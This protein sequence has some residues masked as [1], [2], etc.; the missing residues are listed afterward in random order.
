[1]QSVTFTGRNLRLILDVGGYEFDSATD[2]DDRNWLTGSVE[3]E[4]GSPPVVVVRRL[5]VFWQTTELSEFEGQ[6]RAALKQQRSRSSGRAQLTP[7]EEQVELQVM[8]RL[9]E[10]MISGRVEL[11]SIASVEFHETPTSAEELERALAELTEVTSAFPF[12]P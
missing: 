3:L 9:N 7:L 10:A 8:V 2:L 1:M 11:H 4:V 5:E 6:L 12:R